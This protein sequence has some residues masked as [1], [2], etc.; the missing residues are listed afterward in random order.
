MLCDANCMTFWKQQHFGNTVK[1]PEVDYRKGRVNGQST[2]G[3]LGSKNI[4]CYHNDENTEL[5]ISTNTWDL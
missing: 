2:E 1:M 5:Y 3:F 4:L